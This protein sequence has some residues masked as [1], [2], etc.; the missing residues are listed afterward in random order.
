MRERD[1]GRWEL[2]VYTGRDQAT[3]QPRQ[4]SRTFRGGKRAAAR[5]L[6][7][8]VAEVNEGRHIG[9]AATFA[10]LLE[11]WEK[12]LEGTRSANTADTYRSHIRVR[13]RPTLG[14][15]K[16]R[17]LN[18]SDLDLF[19]GRLQEEGLAVGTVQLVHSIISGALTQAVR[20]GWIRE[21]PARFA[22]P[23][24]ERAVERP[25]VT[26]AQVLDLI[27]ESNFE[28]PDLGTLITLAAFTGCRRGELVGFKWDDV[29][30]PGRTIR[31]RRSLVPAPGGGHREGP[32]KG[33]KER[34]V[35][36]GDVGVALLAAYRERQTVKLG[37]APEGWLLSLDGVRPLRAKAVSNYVS[38]L[39]KRLG[40]P[41]HLHEL[42]HFSLSTLTAEGV[43]VKTVQSRAGHE[44]IEVT[45]KYLHGVTELEQRAA[46]ILGRVLELPPSTSTS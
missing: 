28:D 16:L 23:P 27:E 46:E 17:S 38:T 30:W 45:S 26:P 24:R 9:T 20:W 13:I 12:T 42:R 40:V 39:S 6:D 21:S 1:P 29:D 25:T 37:H 34:T 19:Y 32:P 22:T 18:A 36:I 43:D 31:V 11:R 14:E 3:K 2:R 41:I 44:S 33:G 35:A 7:E 4:V 15:I 8:L 5:A 10:T